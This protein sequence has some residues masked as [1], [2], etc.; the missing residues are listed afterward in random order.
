MKILVAEDSPICMDVL[1]GQMRELGLYEFSNFFASGD[2][3]LKRAVSIYE[4][5]LAKI[6]K[7]GK[8]DESFDM[9][10]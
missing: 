10:K 3:L 9:M 6:L 7:D 5:I 2:Q 1:Q 4:N 8:A